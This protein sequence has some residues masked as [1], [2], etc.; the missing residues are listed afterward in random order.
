MKRCFLK[1]CSKLKIQFQ[2]SQPSHSG[3]SCTGSKYFVKFC[4]KSIPSKN[5]QSCICTG[6]T[7]GFHLGWSG[8]TTSSRLHCLR[9]CLGWGQAGHQI[10]NAPCPGHRCTAGASSKLSTWHRDG[11]MA[12]WR[13]RPVMLLWRTS[14]GL[15]SRSRRGATKG[16]VGTWQKIHEN[17]WKPMKINE[18]QWKSLIS[19]EVIETWHLQKHLYHLSTFSSHLTAEPL[20]PFGFSWHACTSWTSP[21]L[22]LIAA[23]TWSTSASWA[24]SSS[25]TLCFVVLRCASLA[26]LNTLVEHIAEQLTRRWVTL[27][28][29]LLVAFHPTTQLGG[30]TSMAWLCGKLMKMCGVPTY[31]TYVWNFDPCPHPQG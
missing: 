4:S 31:C 14:K 18:N 15:S 2:A 27:H 11:A 19:K 3:S 12:P 8:R 23:M 13:W 24:A 6:A 30:A 10:P 5:Q 25:G 28:K 7:D 21:W 20:L 26:L 17:Q 29:A 16:A 9:H 1:K 22:A